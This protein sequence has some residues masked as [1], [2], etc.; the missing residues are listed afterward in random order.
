MGKM[1][2]LSKLTAGV[3]SFALA[4]GAAG[5][6]PPCVSRNQALASAPGYASETAYEVTIPDAYINRIYTYDDVE[7]LSQASILRLTVIPKKTDYYDYYDAIEI[8][9]YSPYIRS[10]TLDELDKELYEKWDSTIRY[11]DMFGQDDIVTLKFTTYDK[12]EA[13]ALQAELDKEGGYWGSS[14]SSRKYEFEMDF[15]SGVRGLGIHYY[16]DI[17]DD[18]VVDS[19]DSITY[20]KQLAGTIKTELTEIQLLNGDVNM[21]D[22]IDEEDFKMVQDFLLG[23]VKEINGAGEIGSVRLDNT[24]D[25]K[26]SEGKTT[27]A[28]FAAAEMKFGVDIL[29]NSFDPTKKDE[30]NLLVSPMSISAALAMTANGADGETKAEM[31]KVLGNGLTLDQL[32]EYMAYY[33]SKLPN[34]KK[35]K[36]MLADSI[37]FKDKETF[38]VYDEFLEKNKKFYNAELYKAAFDNNTVKD[39]NSWVNRNTQGMIPSLLK[40][41]DLTPTDEKEILMML[42]NTLYFEAEWSNPYTSSRDEKF[43]DLN[44]NEHSIKAMHSQERYYYDLGDA[45]AF[46][47]PYAGGKYS[48]VGIMPKEKD[49]VSYVKDL[50]AEKLFEGLKEYEDPEKIELNVMIPKFKYQYSKSMTKVLIDMGMPTAFDWRNADFS[51]INDLSVEGADPLYIDDVLHKTKIEVTEKGTKAAAVTAV[52]MAAGC[53]MPEPKKE[54]NIFLDKPFVYMIVDENNVPLFI[55]AATQ[56]EEK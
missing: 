47:K 37:W 36:V 6:F 28:E 24:V 20:R 23:K 34:E 40:N 42:I 18:G 52:M 14:S 43:T 1:K 26:A 9:M 7:D 54:I 39:V 10:N 11:C 15:I 35:Q 38:K 2:K 30:E 49:I 29:K 33:I 5:T 22:K 32:N 41:G 8:S 56:L 48:F 12:E 25:V 51:K 44:G 45:D 27:D 3:L 19:F 4:M 55:G 53:A 16:G 21:N 13:D 31:E 46:K 17:N 50:D